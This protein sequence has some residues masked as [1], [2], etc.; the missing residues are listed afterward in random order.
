MLTSG[1][2]EKARVYTLEIVQSNSMRHGEVE[3]ESSLVSSRRRRHATRRKT[4]QTIKTKENE[5]ERR[6]E[7]SHHFPIAHYLGL[8]LFPLLL[9][10]VYKKRAN[11]LFLSPLTHKRNARR[12][13][14]MMI[15]HCPKIVIWKMT[16]NQ[17]VPPPF[18]RS[19]IT[20]KRLR[21]KSPLSLPSIANR[22]DIPSNGI[23]V[24]PAFGNSISPSRQAFLRIGSTE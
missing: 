19:H 17:C 22:V 15:R 20:R 5:K 16:L 10:F 12:N 7:K 3:R 9:I 8:F 23:K 11:S 2:I 24:S 13:D 14:L 4:R 6:A 1:L 21:I 18:Q